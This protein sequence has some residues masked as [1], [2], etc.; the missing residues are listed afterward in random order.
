MPQARILT[1]MSFVHPGKWQ[2][3][4]APTGGIAA[5]CEPASCLQGKP[6]NLPLWR[7]PWSWTSG[8]VKELVCSF[9]V[10]GVEGGC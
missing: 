3:V 1:H 9:V 6:A 7:W 8:T 2:L 4:S 10:G 5:A